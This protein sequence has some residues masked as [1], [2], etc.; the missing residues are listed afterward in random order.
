MGHLRST[1][2]L[3]ALLGLFIAGCGDDPSP[4]GAG[5]DG[6]TG[7]AGGVGGTGGDGGDG[8]DGGTGGDDDGRPRVDGIEPERAGPGFRVRVVGANFN[9][10]G[11]RNRLYFS[12]REGAEQASLESVGVAADP[13]G[14]WFEADVHPSAKTGVTLVTV[15]TAN[16]T[17]S[18]QGPNFTVTDEKLAPD[19]TGVTPTVIT[20]APRNVTLTITGRS[21]YPEITTLTVNGADQPIDWKQSDTQRLVTVLPEER[22]TTAGNLELVVHTPAPG[23]GSSKPALVRVVDPIHLVRAKALARNLVLLTFDRP[24]HGGQGANR[25]SYTLVGHQRAI[26]SARL[27]QGNP[28]QVE[29]E[30]S[31]NT[32]A[33]RDYTM[34]VSENFTS[35]DG[36]EIR[37]REATFRSFGSAPQFVAEIGQTSCGADGFVDPTGVVLGDDAVFVTERGGNQVQV[38]DLEG[39]LEGFYAHD[40]N[41]FAY[42]TSGTASGCGGNPLAL[43]SLDEPIGSVVV[44][45]AFEILVGDTGNDRVLALGDTRTRTFHEGE[46]SPVVVLGVV[47]GKGVVVTDGPANAIAIDFGSG[48]V[49]HTFGSRGRQVGTNAGEFD[50][51]FGATGSPAMAVGGGNYYFV[52][53]GNHRVQRYRSN[54]APGGSIGVGSRNFETNANGSPGTQPGEFTDPS[55]IATDA[56]G[57]LY[58][59]DSAGGLDGGGRLQRFAPNGAVLWTLRLDYVPG[60]VAVDSEREVIWVTNRSR[61]TLMQYTL[62]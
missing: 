18:V 15:E 40:G 9:P 12:S 48:D 31:L 58:V 6:G 45:P 17:V 56:Q 4:G 24:V 8:G 28:H 59:T 51:S 2:L 53:P 22:V 20:T 11:A 10:V 41:S 54:L 46:E 52:E 42:H 26:R 35:A 3:L 61:D 36:G 14:T 62:P 43:A 19:V 16:G 37:T 33:D 39:N 38:V 30:L 27:V 50:F 25:G 55:G 13:D 1:T 57:F 5:G 47:P 49:T 60:G 7:G 29:V 23:G 32:T 21:F 34:R 44:S